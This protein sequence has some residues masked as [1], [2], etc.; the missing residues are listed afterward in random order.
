MAVHDADV[1]P[2]SR[3]RPP[4][5]LFHGDDVGPRNAPGPVAMRKL[6]SL[7]LLGALVAGCSSYAIAPPKQPVLHPFQDIG[8]EAFARVC[9]VRNNGYYA[10]A[11]TF[12][13]HDNGVL[14]GATK[15][16]TYFCYQAEPGRHVL[17][18]EADG[19]SEITFVA[20]AGKSYYLKEEAPFHLWKITPRGAWL[21]DQEAR[22][23][24]EDST[25]EVVVEAPA[26]DTLPGRPAIVK[27]ASN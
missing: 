10:R 3:R 6:A 22:E 25:Y 14:V 16:G 21:D 5:L 4:A 13:T 12:V 24:I 15:G 9:V 20:V 26:K 7:A 11:V 18:L 2:R 27:A 8:G 1:T 17:T 23:E 19:D